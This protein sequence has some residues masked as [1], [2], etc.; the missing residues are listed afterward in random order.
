[1]KGVAVKPHFYPARL[2]YT[3]AFCCWSESLVLWLRKLYLLVIS[4]LPFVKF[5]WKAK[6][7]KQEGFSGEVISEPS[8]L[9]SYFNTFVICITHLEIHWHCSWY[10]AIKDHVQRFWMHKMERLPWCETQWSG[11]TE[12][13]SPKRWGVAIS[14][15]SLLPGATSA[16]EHL[17]PTVILILIRIFSSF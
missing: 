3:K 1:M 12:K 4:T 10:L 7:H 14:H 9:L 11:G 5:N 2:C 8:L 17:Q 13:I 6:L 15:P 16:T